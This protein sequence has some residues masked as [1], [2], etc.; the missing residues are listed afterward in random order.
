MKSN[1]FDLSIR[2]G[3]HKN[4]VEV[5]KDKIKSLFDRYSCIFDLKS[6]KLIISFSDTNIVSTDIIACI[7]LVTEFNVRYKNFCDNNMVIPSEEDVKRDP[8]LLQEIMK[9]LSCALLL[10]HEYD[11]KSLYDILSKEISVFD[12]YYIIHTTAF[13]SI[14]YT[15]KVL[16]ARNSVFATGIDATPMV[17]TAIN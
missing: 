6:G 13:I 16:V 7:S 9:M 8:K 2:F 11:E 14:A 12:F 15:E 17:S 4:T 5:D 3:A 10:F 1:L